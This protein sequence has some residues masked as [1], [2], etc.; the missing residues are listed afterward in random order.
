MKRDEKWRYKDLFLADMREGL[1][2]LRPLL[3]FLGKTD[4]LFLHDGEE[5]L[6]PRKLLEDEG[7]KGL[8]DLDVKFDEYGIHD[9]YVK[10]Q[11]PLFTFAMKCPHCGRMT[12]IPLTKKVKP[13]EHCG[14]TGKRFRPSRHK[15]AP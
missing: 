5:Y 9:F 10:T 2:K 1:W 3:E 12:Q 13:E 7:I 4:G 6:M 15:G 14:C 8:A 11:K